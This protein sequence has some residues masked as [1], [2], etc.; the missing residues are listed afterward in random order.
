MTEIV[1]TQIFK[2]F[3]RFAYTELQTPGWFQRME[4]LC[5]GMRPPHGFNTLYEFQVNESDES[6]KD[7]VI[8]NV[9]FRQ[10]MFSDWFK[11]WFFHNHTSVEMWGPNIVNGSEMFLDDEFMLFVRD[12]S[13]E[14]LKNI[15]EID[16][17]SLK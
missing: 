10:M 14:D 7:E 8:I 16:M 17:I 4:T 6:W 11:C 9:I 13:Y 1:K 15:I 2:E 5:G 3:F 12:L